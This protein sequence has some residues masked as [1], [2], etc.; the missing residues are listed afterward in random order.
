VLAPN[1]HFTV[2]RYTVKLDLLYNMLLLQVPLT[3]LPPLLLLLLLLP[4]LLP[5]LLL[6]LL[7]PSLLLLLLAGN[8]E[9]LY[10]G[11]HSKLFTLPDDTLVY[12]GH[13]YKVRAAAAAAAGGGGG[14][15]A[16]AAAA[17]AAAGTGSCAAAISC[18]QSQP[19]LTT[20]STLSQ[21]IIQ[22]VQRRQTVRA[23]QTDRLVLATCWLITVACY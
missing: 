10:D 21:A 8:A 18:I 17:G 22:C 12:P 14:G 5:P 9:L 23:A 2:T 1:V 15:A 7:P 4:P 13:D 16:A 3:L 11:I 19:M 6:L 20:R